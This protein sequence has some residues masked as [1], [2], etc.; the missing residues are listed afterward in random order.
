MYDYTCPRCRHSGGFVVRA[1][2]DSE[3]RNCTWCKIWWLRDE[4]GWK[5][6]VVEGRWL[7]VDWSL[8]I[9]DE[10]EVVA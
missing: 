4:G 7:A 1:G 2:P 10:R 3:A 6:L 9:L 8:V 5:L